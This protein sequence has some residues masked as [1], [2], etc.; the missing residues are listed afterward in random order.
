MTISDD[1]RCLN[2]IHFT[3]WA[4][5]KTITSISFWSYA[6]QI[7]PVHLSNRKVK[8][9]INL[10]WNQ[11][12]ARHLRQN[13]SSLTTNIIRTLNLH[14]IKTYK[15]L[16]LFVHSVMDVHTITK[17][18]YHWKYLKKITNQS[19][20]NAKEVLYHLSFPTKASKPVD[21]A[22]EGYSCTRNCLDVTAEG[23]RQDLD[24]L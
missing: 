20:K 14:F 6:I 3:P 23:G 22:S 13:I 15:I 21:E 12:L 17:G 1:F 5:W 9:A 10:V 8:N 19:V 4:K 24:C 7:W 2:L 11:I 16:Q 18:V